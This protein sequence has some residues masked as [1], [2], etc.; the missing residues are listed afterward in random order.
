M[1]WFIN[2]NRLRIE[3][4]GRG[5]RFLKGGFDMGLQGVLILNAFKNTL[6]I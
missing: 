5:R 1:R 3:D 4:K 2:L 6:S